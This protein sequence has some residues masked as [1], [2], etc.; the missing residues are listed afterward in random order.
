MRIVQSG[1][2]SSQCTLTQALERSQ[3]SVPPGGQAWIHWSLILYLQVESRE[4]QQK[5]LDLLLERL[6]AADNMA[7]AIR[8]GAELTC[9][10][11]EGRATQ[12]VLDAMYRSGRD[13]DGG[14]VEL[15]PAK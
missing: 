9:T 8:I 14:W 3:T 7:A 13:N 5:G 10:G 11:A 15:I 6:N 4:A 12:S 1:G 2:C